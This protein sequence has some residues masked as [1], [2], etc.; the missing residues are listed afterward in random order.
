[1]STVEI[2]PEQAWTIPTLTN[3][4]GPQLQDLDPGDISSTEMLYLVVFV[5]SLCALMLSWRH[6]EQA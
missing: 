6:R 4:D 2:K 3:F 5:A 1:M